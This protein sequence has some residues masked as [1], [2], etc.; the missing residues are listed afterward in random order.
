MSHPNSQNNPATPEVIYTPG[1]KA[2]ELATL[3]LMII[4]LG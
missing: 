4:F 3:D 2:F 1:P